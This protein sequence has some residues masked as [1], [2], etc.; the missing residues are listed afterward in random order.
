[1]LLLQMVCLVLV[2]RKSLFP[3]FYL[4]QTLLQI[5]FQRVLGVMGPED[6]FWWQGH[7]DWKL[8]SIQC[9]WE[10]VSVT[11]PIELQIVGKFSVVNIQLR[12]LRSWLCFTCWFGNVTSPFFDVTVTGIVVGTALVDA[13]LHAIVDSGTSF[14]YLT[15]PTY[16]LVSQSVGISPVSLSLSSTSC[17]S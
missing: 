15:N 7:Y 12:G 8:H 9:Q 6:Y 5:P 17:T 13:G 10:T 1:M 11:L 4:Q 14:T 2:W 3:S 16:V